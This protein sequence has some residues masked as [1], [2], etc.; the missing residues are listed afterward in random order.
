MTKISFYQSMFGLSPTD[1]LIRNYF[2]GSGFFAPLDASFKSPHPVDIFETEDSLVIEL[3][4]CGIKKEDITINIEDDGILRIE[5]LKP[6]QKETI[7]YIQRGISRKS[8]S[9]GYRINPRFN[10]KDIDASL[11]DGLL[12]IKI[13]LSEERKPKT[14]KIN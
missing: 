7:S 2:D 8:F 10:L 4:A 3:A 12:R 5:Y 11:S 1:I 6:E 9:L 13:P 14:I